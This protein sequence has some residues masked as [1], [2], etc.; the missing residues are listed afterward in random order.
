ML[1]SVTIHTSFMIATPLA[2]ERR[3]DKCTPLAR[4]REGETNV[5]EDKKKFFFNRIPG[6]AELNFQNHIYWVEA[7]F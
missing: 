7:E 1:L 6:R 4:E 3:G 5:P 2:R